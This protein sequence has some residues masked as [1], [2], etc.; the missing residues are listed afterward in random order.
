MIFIISKVNGFLFAYKKQC[1][2]EINYQYMNANQWLG[3][4]SIL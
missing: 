1:S 4:K 3:I 2:K